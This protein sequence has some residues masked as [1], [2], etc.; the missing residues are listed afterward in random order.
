MTHI[1]AVYAYIMLNLKGNKLLLLT[2]DP[3]K[4]FTWCLLTIVSKSINA[5]LP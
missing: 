3:F 4:A 5:A 1:N 2:P